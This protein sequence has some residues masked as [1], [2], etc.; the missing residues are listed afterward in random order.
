MSH[1]MLIADR[2]IVFEEED[3]NEEDTMTGVEKVK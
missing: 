1:S 3:D 2:S